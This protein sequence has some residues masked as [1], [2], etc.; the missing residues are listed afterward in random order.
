MLL[1]VT[2]WLMNENNIRLKAKY[3]VLSSSRLNLAENKILD[4]LKDHLS[5]VLSEHTKHINYHSIRSNLVISS[6]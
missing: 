1:H 6:T 4:H 2:L 5:C 3:K